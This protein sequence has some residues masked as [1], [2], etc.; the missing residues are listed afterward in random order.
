MFVM[1]T[2]ESP[3]MPSPREVEAALD[4]LVSHVAWYQGYENDKHTLRTALAAAQEDT[5]RLDWLERTTNERTVDIS[6]HR[7]RWGVCVQRKA[8]AHGEQ[9][10]RG[11]DIRAALDAARKDTTDG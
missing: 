4:R 10:G 8:D 5:A 2:A 11:N 3:P 9:F 1:R 7:A 6:R